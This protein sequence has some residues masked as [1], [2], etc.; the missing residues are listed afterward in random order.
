MNKVISSISTSTIQTALLRSMQSTQRDFVA[1]QV[2]V[3]TSS[4]AD[5]AVQLGSRTAIPLSLSH[6]ISRIESILQTNKSAS[7]RLAA[8]QDALASVLSSTQSLF[9]GLA[10]AKGSSQ[11]VALASQSAKVT[12]GAIVSALNAEVAGQH[13]FSGLNMDRPP[14][15]Q[16]SGIPAGADMDA[17]FLS[18]FG[19]AKS[20]A[21]AASITPAAFTNFI[22]LQVQPLFM[23]AAW[24]TAVSSASDDTITSLIGFSNI[25][26]TSVSANETS[27]RQ[28]L[29]AAALSANFLDTPLS[30]AAKAVIVDQSLQQSSASIS[31]LAALQGKVGF[32]QQRINDSDAGLSARRDLFAGMA[33]GLTGVDPHEAAIR[34]NTLL[35]K[36]ETSYALTQ[37]IQR[38]SILDYLG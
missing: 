22:Q 10:A 38:L 32:V 5:V 26:E 1:A 31:G 12:L 28:G 36:L 4:Y 35:T 16:A 2:E 20:D 15:S 13:I 29:Y 19:F 33:D 21:A 3:Q 27:V 37:K 24:G 9:D 8:T 25:A 14:F 30:L 34:L 18:H 6:D 11:A 23:G 17:A 7:A